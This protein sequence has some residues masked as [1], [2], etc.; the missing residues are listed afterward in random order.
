MKITVSRIVAIVSLIL[1]F[2]ASVFVQP[3]AATGIH[4]NAQTVEIMNGSLLWGGVDAVWFY[5]NQ[6][7]AFTG[8]T[9]PAINVKWSFE[10]TGASSIFWYRCDYQT[11]GSEP[12]IAGIIIW[13]SNSSTMEKQIFCNRNAYSWAHNSASDPDGEPLFGIRVTRVGGT[14]VSLIVDWVSTYQGARSVFSQPP[15]NLAML[16]LFL[17]LLLFVGLPVF[18][19]TVRYRGNRH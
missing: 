12:T 1:L 11:D 18:L 9:N 6:T 14:Y 16:W 19:F 3:N 2:L 17:I 10:S 4:G 7:Q 8:T 13:P 5:D 15:V